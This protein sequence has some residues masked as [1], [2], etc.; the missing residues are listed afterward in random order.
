MN[1]VLKPEL[2]RFVADRVKTGQYADAS[3]I[4]NEALK[5]LMEQEEFTPEQEA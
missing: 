1:V 4:V 3:D 2:E 5:V